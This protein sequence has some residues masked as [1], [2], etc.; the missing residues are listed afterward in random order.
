[1]GTD[2]RKTTRFLIENNVIAA[3]QGGFTIIGE[4]K[5]ISLGG[6]SFE[7]IYDGNL[8]QDPLKKEISLL[9]KGFSFPK[10]QCRLVYEIPVRPPP[11]YQGFTIYFVSKRCGVQF[12]T[13][14]EDQMAQLG[15]FIKAHTIEILL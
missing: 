7:H 4:V 2:Q 9:V 14:S 13:L 1:M 8:I 5:D 11:E 10:M 15:S 3:F 6:L 12:E